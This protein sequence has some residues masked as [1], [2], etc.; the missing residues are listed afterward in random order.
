MQVFNTTKRK[1][2][3]Q[4]LRSK[5]DTN[6]RRKVA[7]EY[8][9]GDRTAVQL[10]EQYGI[11]QHNVTDWVRKF[12]S[13]LAVQQEVI[14]I[15]TPEEQKELEALKRQLAAV[16][17]QLDYEQMKNFALETMIDLAKDELG[18]DLRKNS[19]AKQPKK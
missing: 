16:K 9:E 5:Y 12:S 1:K 15:M 7:R 8:L 11:K 3:Q 17:E 6:F 4:G 18:V 13:D 14:P 19:G 10:A 2:G